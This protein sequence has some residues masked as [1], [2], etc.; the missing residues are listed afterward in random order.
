L[1]N[2]DATRWLFFSFLLLLL[3]PE[4]TVLAAA[5]KTVCGSLR[6]L[7]LIGLSS[8]PS[9]TEVSLHRV[10]NRTINAVVV[11]EAK[12]DN[13]CLLDIQLLQQ[14]PIDA[15][16]DLAR[17]RRRRRGIV[18]WYEHCTKV[19]STRAIDDEWN[20]AMVCGRAK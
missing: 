5:D 19:V 18:F 4:M 16:E 14:Y 8:N 15:L 1:R 10:V 9:T 7:T 2:F 12:E 11:V 6:K 17:F 3:L 20:C 13:L